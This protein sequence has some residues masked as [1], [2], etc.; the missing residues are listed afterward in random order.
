MLCMNLMPLYSLPLVIFAPN[1]YISFM[2]CQRSQSLKTTKFIRNRWYLSAFDAFA[3]G[4]DWNARSLSHCACLSGAFLSS[5]C[6]VCY[7][8]AV[9]GFNW[10]LTNF[11]NEGVR[12][13]RE[14]NRVCV[15]EMC[16]L[17]I[18]QELL[19]LVMHCCRCADNCDHFIWDLLVCDSFIWDRIDLRLVEL[20]PV[21]LRFEIPIDLRSRS[22]GTRLSFLTKKLKILRRFDRGNGKERKT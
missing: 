16:C 15:S 11:F 5:Q 4:A 3:L 18:K 1:I 13:L 8:P 21:H 9:L 7:A 10:F 17:F 14:I 20:R 6:R 12:S 22:R 2:N 19:W